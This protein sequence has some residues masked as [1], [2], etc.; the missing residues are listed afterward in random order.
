MI[1][2]KDTVPAPKELSVQGEVYISC[3]NKTVAE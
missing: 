2:N 3:E 1:I